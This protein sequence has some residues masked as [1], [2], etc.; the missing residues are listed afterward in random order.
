MHIKY[1][2]LLQPIENPIIIQHNLNDLVIFIAW[3]Y[4][5]PKGVSFPYNAIAIWKLKTLTHD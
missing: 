5:P 1:G 3:P 2:K 4:L